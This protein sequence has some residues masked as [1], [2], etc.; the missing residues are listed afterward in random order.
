MAQCADSGDCGFGA[1]GA[2]G[3]ADHTFEAGDFEA[4]GG[5]AEGAFEGDRFADIVEHGA[6]AVRHHHVD[7]LCFE[8]GH[9]QRAAEG[10]GCAVSLG[11][12]RGD[13]I[14]ISGQFAAEHLGVE[15]GPAGAGVFF[16]L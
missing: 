9:L 12:G 3:M 4:V 7:L 5:G 10:A 8:S 6:G 14:G 15:C 2:E 11:F 13:M 16:G 1:G